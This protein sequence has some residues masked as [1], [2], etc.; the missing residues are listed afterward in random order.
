M[1]LVAKP[2]IIEKVWAQLNLV[3]EP[4]AHGYSFNFI[5]RGE[6]ML[7]LYSVGVQMQVYIKYPIHRGMRDPE[8]LRPSSDGLFLT[9]TD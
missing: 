2:D 3:L 8:L 7:Y 5:S 6:L 1:S 9:L 4:L